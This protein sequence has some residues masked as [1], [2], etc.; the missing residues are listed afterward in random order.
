DDGCVAF[1]AGVPKILGEAIL[2]HNSPGSDL[3]V[4]P[5]GCVLNE[6]EQSGRPVFFRSITPTLIPTQT[7]IDDLAAV[8]EV[9]FVGYPSGLYDEHNATPLVRRGITATP[10]WNNFQGQPAFLID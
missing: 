9:T 3:A 2:K 8:E 5:V 7:A 1:C 10:P 4:V 6:L